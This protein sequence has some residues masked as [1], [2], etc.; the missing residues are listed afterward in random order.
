MLPAFSTVAYCIACLPNYSSSWGT[1]GTIGVGRFAHDKSDSQGS[2]THQL[3]LEGPSCSKVVVQRLPR[4]CIPCPSDCPTLVHR[5]GHSRLS[6]TFM[7]WVHRGDQARRF[8]KNCN[9]RPLYT[10]SGMYRKS[11]VRR[12]QKI[13]RPG[14][15][16]GVLQPWKG[17]RREPRHRVGPASEGAQRQA[18]R[19]CGNGP[20]R[21]AG[22]PVRPAASSAHRG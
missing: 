10:S 1:P 12:H 17:N 6:K 3:L 15:R 19:C 4:C 8:T 20:R 14:R 13:S 22:A 9:D 16:K 5:V 7:G 11:R 18:R 2:P 21:I